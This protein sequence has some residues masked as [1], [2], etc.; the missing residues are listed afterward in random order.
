MIPTTPAPYHLLLPIATAMIPFARLQLLILIQ[1]PPPSPPIL[2]H[3]HVSHYY[4]VNFVLFYLFLVY[5]NL[6]LTD[7]VITT[8]ILFLIF[9]IDV[10]WIHHFLNHNYYLS[11]YLFIIKIKYYL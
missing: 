10:N 2:L 6:P 7:H 3:F 9:A 11:I 8:T 1:Q 5:I 4:F